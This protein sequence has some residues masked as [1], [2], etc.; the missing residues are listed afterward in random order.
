M[1]LDSYIERAWKLC[2]K[3]KWRPAFEYYIWR[4]KWFRT[5]SLEDAWI[6]KLLPVLK[7]EEFLC[8]Q[9]AGGRF[10]QEIIV[11]MVKLVLY[12]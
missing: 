2:S 10:Y 8:F 6:Y 11:Y 1:G 7:G 12:G 9:I 4:K 5:R 3:T